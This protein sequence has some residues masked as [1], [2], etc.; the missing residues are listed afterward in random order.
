MR[1]DMPPRSY[2][3]MHPEARLDDTET[4]ELARGLDATFGTAHTVATR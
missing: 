1:R 2:K 4:E 3:M